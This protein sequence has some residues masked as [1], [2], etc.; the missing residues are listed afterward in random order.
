[1]T[2]LISLYDYLCREKERAEKEE[3]NERAEQCHRV[4]EF[5]NNI[6]K[7]TQNK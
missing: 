5:I 2:G 6:E 3:D 4:I 1:M 7:R